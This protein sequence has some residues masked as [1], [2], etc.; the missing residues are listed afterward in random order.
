MPT[1]KNYHVHIY[2]EPETRAIAE[3]VID[4][5]RA[6]FPL[7]VGHMHD[8]PVGPHPTGSCQ[9]TVMPEHFGDVIAWLMLNRQGL[10]IF[11]HADTGDVMADHTAHT[12]WMGSMPELDLDVLRGLV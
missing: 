5:A 3:Q 9:L 6:A 11:T 7:A 12:M 4:G 10:T 1:V 8:R 2:F